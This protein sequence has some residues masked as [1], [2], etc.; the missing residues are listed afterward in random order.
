MGALAAELLT[1]ASRIGGELMDA[2]RALAQRASLPYSTPEWMLAF[3]RHYHAPS[4]AQLRV[5]VVR[6]GARIVGIGPFYGPERAGPFGLAE[7]R[8]L[9]AG[10][11]Q[12]TAPLAEPGG[13]AEVARACARALA[14]AEPAPSALFLDAMDAGSPWP[15]ALAA[16]WPG[17]LRPKLRV[18]GRM[19]GLVGHTGEDHAAWLKARSRNYRRQ[20]VRRR[21]EIESRGGVLRRS[22]TSEQ[23]TA[24][25]DALFRL[26]RERFAGQ[27]RETS[28]GDPYRAAIGE[29]AAALFERD[30]ARLLVIEAG[31]E[32]VGAQL[33]LLAGERLCAWNGGISPEWERASLGLVLFDEGMRDAHELGARV[34]DFGSGD[35]AYKAHFTDSDEPLAWTALLVRDA[36]YPAVR[37]TLAPAQLREGV[38]ATVRRMPPGAERVARRLLGR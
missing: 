22:T 38:R 33:F 6:N 3:W 9:A 16:A 17:R 13:E 23:L 29:A 30:A 31:G 26:H 19:P 27:G 36:R 14:A 37:A 12:R 35:Q 34:L 18:N 25:L 20:Q 10:I 15:A 4:G 8:L 2:W 28:L 21:R 11:G 1:D 7:H 32:V 5:V 24:D